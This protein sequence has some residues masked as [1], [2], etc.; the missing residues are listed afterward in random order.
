M[1]KRNLFISRTPLLIYTEYK[2]FQSIFDFLLCPFECSYPSV[3]YYFA[4][5]H[6]FYHFVYACKKPFFHILFTPVLT[7]ASF[8]AFATAGATLLSK[9][10]GMI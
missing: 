5:R 6:A 7:A 4:R 8:T 10:E 1:E 2:P 9:G 3:S